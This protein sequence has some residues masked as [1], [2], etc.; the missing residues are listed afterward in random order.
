[1]FVLHIHVIEGESAIAIKVV[2]SFL[3]GIEGVI[4]TS[5]KDT[6]TWSM[7]IKGYCIAL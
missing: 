4:G 3:L 7:E 5:M 1:M 6:Y 2:L